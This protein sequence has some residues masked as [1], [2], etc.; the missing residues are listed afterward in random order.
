MPVVHHYIYVLIY[1]TINQ[2]LLVKI[3]IIN[4]VRGKQSQIKTENAQ[5]VSSVE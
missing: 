3:V 4:I 5:I 2:Y 1:Q